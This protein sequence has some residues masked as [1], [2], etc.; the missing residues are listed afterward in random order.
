MQEWTCKLEYVPSLYSKTVARLEKLDEIAVIPFKISFAPA[1]ILTGFSTWISSISMLL[2]YLNRPVNINA[3]ITLV[4]PE[5]E[6]TK[7]TRK[8]WSIV[9]AGCH[10]LIRVVACTGIRYTKAH[11]HSFDDGNCM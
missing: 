4:S 2:A 3:F 1:T 8:G 11:R 9:D 5:E 7:A 6:M 10:K